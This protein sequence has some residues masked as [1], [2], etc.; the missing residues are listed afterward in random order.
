MVLTYGDLV[1]EVIRIYILSLF[2]NNMANRIYFDAHI[3]E[4]FN[5][6]IQSYPSIKNARRRIKQHYRNHYR[7]LILDDRFEFRIKAAN[8]IGIFATQNVIDIGSG[9]FVG[10]FTQQLSQEDAYNHSSCV[11]RNLMLRSNNFA[12]ARLSQYWV[13]IGSIALL[14]HACNNCSNVL[15]YQFPS[16]NENSQSDSMYR[17]ITQVKSIYEG[18][19]VCISYSDDDNEIH[20]NCSICFH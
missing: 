11:Q 18:D 4:F 12:K 19:E 17:V 5:T 9:V 1:H 10:A 8:S 7:L 15:P 13:L 14:N 3:I 20:Y 6:Y 2:L 16:A